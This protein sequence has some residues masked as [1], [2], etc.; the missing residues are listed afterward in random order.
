M[1]FKNSRYQTL[2]DNSSNQKVKERPVI[3]L[4][5][6]LEHVVQDGERLDQIA[7][8]YY[9]D[10]SLWWKILDANPEIRSAVDFE[11]KDYTGQILLIPGLDK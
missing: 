7:V 10:A 4:N 1:I 3:A 8:Y 9:E 6:L 11:I 5:G 2:C